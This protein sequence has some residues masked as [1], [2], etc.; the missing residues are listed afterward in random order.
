MDLIKKLFTFNSD[1]TS[2]IGLC[3]FNDDFFKNEEAKDQIK[4]RIKKNATK[5]FVRKYYD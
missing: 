4:K 2:A 1:E 5:I 3:R